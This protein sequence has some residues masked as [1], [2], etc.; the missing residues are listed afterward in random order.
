MSA[1]R[2]PRRR[3]RTKQFKRAYMR[4]RQDFERGKEIQDSPYGGEGL[5]SNKYREWWLIGWNERR[6]EFNGK[7]V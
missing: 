3:P 2:E 1:S 7:E 4:G 6:E 5:F